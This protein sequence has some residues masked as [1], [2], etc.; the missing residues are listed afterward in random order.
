MNNMN[1]SKVLLVIGTLAKGGAEVQL[2]R[3]ARALKNSNCI[4]DMIV[5]ERGG[6]LEQ[7]A[8]AS[9]DQLF[10]CDFN[11][12][13]GKFKKILQL[14]LIV[15]K[16][17]RLCRLNQYDVMQSYLPMANLIGSLGGKIGGV[18]KI[19]TGR[20]AL[21]THQ[22]RVPF[23]KYMDKL[24][25]WFSDYVTCNAIMVKDDCIIREGFS[26]KYLVINN[27]ASKS[28]LN[29]STLF[30]REQLGISEL[31]FV[32]VVV[33][34]LIPYKGHKY[35]IEALSL[36][37]INRNKIKLLIIGEDRGIK[38]DLEILVNEYGLVSEIIWLGLVD[39]VGPFYQIANAYVSSSLEE[40]FSNSIMEAMQFGLPIVATDVGGTSELLCNGKFGVLVP[41]KNSLMLANAMRMIMECYPQ[42]TDIGIKAKD[43]LESEFSEANIVAKYKLIYEIK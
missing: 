5:F 8:L 20:R 2:L 35:L 42:Y 31:D 27:I 29:R 26:Y 14:L 6:V 15:F 41:P 9:T 24:S 33:A 17:F 30:S 13:S 37:S 22:D 32:F 38:R 3:L 25:T 40:G 11:S 23:W 18:K 34:N 43:Y 10:F 19:V 7:E 21:N 39:D 16:I 4:V 28:F 36:L 12:E 1:K